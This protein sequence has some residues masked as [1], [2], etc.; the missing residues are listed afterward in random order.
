VTPPSTAN[1][2]SGSRTTVHHAALA[3]GRRIGRYEIL[4]VLGQGELSGP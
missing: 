4:G 2:P 3:A 1:Q